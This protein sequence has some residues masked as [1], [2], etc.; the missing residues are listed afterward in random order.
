MSWLFSRAMVGGSCLGGQSDGQQ[1]VQS[2]ETPT[3]LV[4]SRN[5]RTTAFSRLSRSGA[6]TFGTLT[7]E[8]GAALLMSYLRALPKAGAEDVAPEPQETISGPKWRE[9]SM[10]FSRSTSSWNIDDLS[11]DGSPECLETWPRW[12]MMRDGACWARTTPEPRSAARG[13]G[14]LEQIAWLMGWPSGWRP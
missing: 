7:D 12:G 6:V 1:S 11:C 14:S 3:A 2:S 10:R 9:L 5:G 4:C 8:I 13:Y